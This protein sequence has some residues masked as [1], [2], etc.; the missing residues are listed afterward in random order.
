L[1][2]GLGMRGGFLGG[3]G[4][5]GLWVRLVGGEEE[6]GWPCIGV[7]RH[8][9]QVGESESFARTVRAWIEGR[10]SV[11]E[12]GGFEDLVWNS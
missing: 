4:L 2:I 8:A 7:I 1:G 5:M 11:F 12:E 6:G 3:L 10:E 9:W